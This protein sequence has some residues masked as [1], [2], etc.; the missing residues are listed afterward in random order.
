MIRVAIADD[1]KKHLRYHK[2]IYRGV[3]YHLRYGF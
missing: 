3:C 2:E 1:E